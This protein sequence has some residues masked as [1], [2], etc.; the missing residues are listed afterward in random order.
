MRVERVDS[1]AGVRRPE[2]CYGGGNGRG[3]GAVRRLGVGERAELVEVLG[4]DGE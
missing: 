2:D 3:S 1:G 4:L